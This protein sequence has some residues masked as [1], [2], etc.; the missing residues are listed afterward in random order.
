MKKIMIVV[1]LFLASCSNYVFDG[2]PVINARVYNSAWEVVAEASI[3]AKVLDTDVAL[4]EYVAD[5]NASHTDDQLFLIEGKDIVPIE[6]APDVDAWIVD[7]ATYI[8]ICEYLDWP[9]IDL[10]ERR[11]TW[12]MQT[13]AVGGIL[14]VD[15]IPP[16]PDPVV[17]TRTDYEKYALYLVSITGS[18]IYEEHCTDW[19]SAGYD[20]IESYFYARKTAYEMTATSRADGSYV[21]SGIIYIP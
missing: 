18:I 21:V 5:Y 19:E 14:F 1:A 11:E 17:D 8:P 10:T 20:S 3:D 6:Q 2:T 15:R 13:E 4:S 7:P 12:R 9:R 16:V